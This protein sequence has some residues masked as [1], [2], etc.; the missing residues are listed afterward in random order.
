MGG[1]PRTKGSPSF[2][3]PPPVIDCDLE[4]DLDDDDDR[5]DDDDNYTDDNDDYDDQCDDDNYFIR[6]RKGD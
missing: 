1:F 4:L 6:Y 3:L 5:S 2:L